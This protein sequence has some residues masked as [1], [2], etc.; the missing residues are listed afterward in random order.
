MSS[1]SVLRENQKKL[2]EVF[3]RCSLLFIL[4]TNYENILCNGICSTKIIK[5][6]PFVD[7]I[8]RTLRITHRNFFNHAPQ[9][10]QYSPK[11]R[12]MTFNS[13]IVY[14]NTILYMSKFDTILYALCKD[15]LKCDCNECFVCLIVRDKN[16]KTKLD[17]RF[18]MITIKYVIVKHELLSLMNRTAMVGDLDNDDNDK[19]INDIV[20]NRNS[21]LDLFIRD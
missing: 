20:S 6:N 9:K 7:M 2:D 13:S 18:K 14:N 10:Q 17:N 4:E 15:E 12:I 21:I 3:N 1:L 16:A 5:K 8:E 11:H 19:V